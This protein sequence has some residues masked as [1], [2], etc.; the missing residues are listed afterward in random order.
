MDENIKE[1]FLTAIRELIQSFGLSRYEQ[2]YSKAKRLPNLDYTACNTFKDWVEVR[3]NSEIFL[4]VP[5]LN[6]FLEKFSGELF[7]VTELFGEDE[8]RS[9][10]KEATFS[11]TNNPNSYIGDGSYLD[12]LE[13][14]KEI[15]GGESFKFNYS[16]KK[17]KITVL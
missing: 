5:E 6:E 2:Q 16:Q 13:K 7:I 17:T 15:M 3:L 14:V 1:E 4:N 9:K 8:K 10:F 12:E 11:I